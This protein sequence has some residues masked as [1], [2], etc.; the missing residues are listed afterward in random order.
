MELSASFTR[1]LLNGFG[2]AY[3]DLLRIATRSAGSRDAGRDLLHDT[4]LR[5]AEHAAAAAPEGGGAD[6][7]RDAT[8]YLA[9]MA[10]HLALDQHRRGQRLKRHV[11]EE[12]RHAQLAPPLW[13]DVAES[14]MYRQALA[15][16]EQAL[17]GLPARCRAVFMAHRMHGEKL[18]AIAER[19]AVSVNTVERDLMLAGDRIEAALLRWR[20]TPAVTRQPGR[21]RS[22]AVLL[23]VAGLGVGGTLGWRM[24]QQQLAAQVLWQAALDSPHGRQTRHSLPDGSSVQLDAQSRAEVQ[25]LRHARRV[26]LVQ[27]AAFFA[28]AHAPERPSARSPSMLAACRSRC[29]APASASNACP[30]MPCSCRSSPAACASQVRALRHANSAQVKPCA[31]KPTVRQWRPPPTKPP[32]GAMANWCFWARHCTRHWHGSRATRPMR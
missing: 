17:A 7:P 32:P 22:L 13:P 5:L 29:W 2:P 8:A 28:V 24:W 20:G 12:T 18:P 30:A 27:G 6:Q 3:A 26:Q 21:R 23:G 31:C 4:W 15:V 16:L 10:Q 9:V 1:A 25:Y 14:V 11:E 19:L